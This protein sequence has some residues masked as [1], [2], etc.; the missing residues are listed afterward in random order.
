M[1]RTFSCVSDGYLTDGK[2]VLAG[3]FLEHKR[4]C[5][6]VDRGVFEKRSEFRIDQLERSI[7]GVVLNLDD[8][9][10]SSLEAPA[11]RVWCGLRAFWEGL[12]SDK[13]SDGGLCQVSEFV[14]IESVEPKVWNLV[15]EPA[16][17]GANTKVPCNI[18]IRAAAIHE[19][20]A[21][22]SFRSGHEEF[23]G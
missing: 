2:K 13:E 11:V 8:H 19:G 10:V 15:Y 6:I 5:E 14:E 3:S 7:V 4:D 16:I 22:L 9:R 23:L 18:E 17:F 1:V 20:A 21:R 12:E